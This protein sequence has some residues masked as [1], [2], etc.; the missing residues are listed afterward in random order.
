VLTAFA[1]GVTVLVVVNIVAL[2][3]AQQTYQRDK[4]ALQT[5][6]IQEARA[7]DQEGFANWSSALAGKERELREFVNQHI[8]PIETRLGFLDSRL[9]QI[10]AISLTASETAS[11][12]LAQD[13]DKQGDQAEAEGDHVR[14][15]EHFASAAVIHATSNR[16]Y[17]GSHLVSLIIRNLSQVKP[18]DNVTDRTLDEI[19]SNLQKV[20]AAPPPNDEASRKIAVAVAMLQAIRG[21]RKQQDEIG[22]LDLSPASPL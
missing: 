18:S 10:A 17:W 20:D 3:F 9:D 11:L 15:A 8:G 6:L 1:A 13:I 2:V 4:D 21:S 5:V 7:L 22:G 19:T 16:K 12:L 14:A